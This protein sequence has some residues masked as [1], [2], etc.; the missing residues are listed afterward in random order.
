VFRGLV[1]GLVVF[2]ILALFIFDILLPGE[3]FN[4]LNVRT[5]DC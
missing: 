4:V 3:M 2:L 5:S 1:V